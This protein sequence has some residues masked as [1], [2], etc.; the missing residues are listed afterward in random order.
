M[1]IGTGKR[2]PGK[3]MKWEEP[4]SLGQLTFHR[5]VLLMRFHSPILSCLTPRWAVAPKWLLLHPRCILPYS[6]VFPQGQDTG[7][8]MGLQFC[9][10]R[11]ESPYVWLEGPTL[12]LR[13]D[14]GP[15]PLSPSLAPPCPN[16][17]PT[18]Q[19][20]LLPRALP[21]LS[22]MCTGLLAGTFQCGLVLSRHRHWPGTE[23]HRYALWIFVA[24][25]VRSR[26]GARGWR[27]SS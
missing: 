2:N 15:T 25:N 18:W 3:W 24:L 10:H 16:P 5:V 26:T 21:W 22:G 8:T 12:G 4:S 19:I 11:I 27:W 17:L 6:P 23:S 14:E 1:I 13:Y 9:W 20:S 7:S